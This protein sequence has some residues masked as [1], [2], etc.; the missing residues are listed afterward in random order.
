M[1]D[2]YSNRSQDSQACAFGDV[3]RA[4]ARRRRST[5]SSSLRLW[6]SSTGWAIATTRRID[7]TS[8]KRFTLSQETQKIVKG[9]KQTATITY[10][11]KASGFEQ[12]KGMLDRYANLSPKIHVQY[13]DYQKQPTVATGLRPAFSRHGLRRN[14]TAHEK[15]RSR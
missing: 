9:L 5:R 13:I 6:C 10:I 15:K 3:R 2:A 12:A 11:D 8:N 7:T 4:M 1:A 14:R